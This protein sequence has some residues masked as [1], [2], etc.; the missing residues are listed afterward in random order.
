MSLRYYSSEAI[1]APQ[2]L[3][4]WGDFNAIINYIID[5]G[6]VSTADS[7]EWVS[8]GKVKITSTTVLKYQ[9]SQVIA[10]SGCNEA[11]YNGEYFIETFD[12]ESKSMICYRST[13]PD[14]LPKETNVGAISIRVSGCGMER[15]FGGVAD[16]RTVFKTKNGIQFR[17]D[18]RNIYEMMQ[19]AQTPNNFWLKFAR[20]SMAEEYDALDS[21]DYENKKIFPF[22]INRPMENFYPT[23]LYTG[24]AWVNTNYNNIYGDSTNQNEQPVNYLNYKNTTNVYAASSGNNRLYWDIYANDEVMYIYMITYANKINKCATRCYVFGEYDCVN[25]SFKNGYMMHHRFSETYNLSYNEAISINSGNIYMFESSAYRNS[26]YSPTIGSSGYSVYN[27]WGV[28]ILDNGASTTTIS[29]HSPTFATYGMVNS[30]YVISS[31]NTSG[32]MGYPNAPDGKIYTSDISVC[33]NNV[34]YGVMKHV[35]WILSGI[36]SNYF[37]NS[38]NL[39][40]NELVKIDNNYYITAKSSQYSNNKNSWVLYK[41]YRP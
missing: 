16:L 27:Q 1:D 32:A 23:G 18:D 41:L 19:P 21:C 38:G 29:A 35:R 25:P 40:H 4:R 39:L 28:A 5:G 20:V 33:N 36:G 24:Q 17:I 37:L 11:L 7:I 9:R 12:A 30:D 22:N 2:L 6:S 31:G 26:Q 13:I 14:N 10:V 15:V 8:V 34:F 3:N